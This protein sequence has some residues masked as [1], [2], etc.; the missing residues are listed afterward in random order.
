MG[1]V[2]RYEDM[3]TKGRLTLIWQEG[4]DIALNIV[5]ENGRMAG[6]EFCNS[7]TG[8]GQS[9][10]TVKALRDLFQAIE[11]DNKEHPITRVRDG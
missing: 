3:S 1:K 10:N 5:D 8:G 2:T 7:V 4:G 11:K 9:P 6:I